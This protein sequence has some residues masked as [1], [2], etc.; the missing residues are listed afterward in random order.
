MPEDTVPVPV[1]LET[2]GRSPRPRSKGMLRFLA[3]LGPDALALALPDGRVVWA[4]PAI[5]AQAEAN[6]IRPPETI[7]RACGCRL[8]AEDWGRIT[9]PCRSHG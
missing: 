3:S 2:E 4:D 1:V 6:A 8:D 9:K 7:I 5:Q